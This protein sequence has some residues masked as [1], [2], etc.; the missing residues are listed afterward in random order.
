MPGLRI[1]HQTEKG[2]TLI[3]PHPGGGTVAKLQKEFHIRLDSDGYAIV[4]ETVWQGLEECKAF[5]F[6]P[7]LVFVNEIDK[8]PTQGVGFLPTNP[9]E[10]PEV[11]R[12]GALRDSTPSSIEKMK[13]S[14]IIPKGV[15]ATVTKLKTAT[16]KETN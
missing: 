4:S 3:V 7:L 1:R 5:G 13:R 2:V 12:V 15:T 16:P 11:K 8:P 9:T 6:D 10:V 14:G